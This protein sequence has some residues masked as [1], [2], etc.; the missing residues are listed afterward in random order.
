M[1]ID[2]KGWLSAEDGDPCIKQFPTAR[3]SPLGVPAPMGIVWHWT[4]GRGGP[5]FGEALARQAQPYRRGID[6]PASWHVLIAKDGTIYQSAPLG[7]GTWHVGRPG[8]VAGRRF[9]N[10]NR[11]TIGCELENAGR[12]KVIDGRCYCWPYWS[13]PGAP[14]HELRADPRLLVESSRAVVVSTEGLFDKYT[15]DQERSA[16]HLLVAL[17]AKYGWARDVCSYG[18]VDFDWPRKEDPGPLWKQVHLKRV[19]EA[20][21]DGGLVA[22]ASPAPIRAQGA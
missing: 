12:L 21:F 18:H 5:G 20:A 2:D 7:V 15:P 16:L 14:K 11:A 6:R 10:I 9:E 19:L 22:S 3:T 1:R 13:N 8:T 4:A 17:A